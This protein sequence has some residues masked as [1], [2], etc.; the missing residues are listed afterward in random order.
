MP[1]EWGPAFLNQ[2]LFEG[3][4]SIIESSNQFKKPTVHYAIKVIGRIYGWSNV[5]GKHFRVLLITIPEKYLY[6]CI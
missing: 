2:S 5:F 6:I 4:F 1:Q 3:I